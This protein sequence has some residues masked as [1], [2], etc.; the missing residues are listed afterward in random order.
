M[1]KMSV[2]GALGLLLLVETTL[3]AADFW[4]ERDFTAWSDKEV[5]KMLTDSPWARTVSVVN[6]DASLAGRVGGLSGG[7]LGR[8]TGSRA[9]AGAGGGVGGDGAGNLG[10]GSFLAS[11]ERVNIAVR[12]SSALPIRQALARRLSAGAPGIDPAATLA[13][14][15]SFYRVSV[16]GVPSGALASADDLADVT[17]LNRNSAPPLQPGNIHALYEND[18][19]T[20]E[21]QFPKTDSI[22]LVHREVEFVTRLGD[23]RIKAKFRLR[24][25]L[26]RSTLAL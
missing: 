4:V 24:D 10:G 12:W 25:M 20:I 13:G 9:G 17:R 8:G 15:E 21:F 6:F 22:T 26:L 14:D 1:A 11:P 2:T 16:V 7:V 23:V 18:V 3:V 5:Q 19:L